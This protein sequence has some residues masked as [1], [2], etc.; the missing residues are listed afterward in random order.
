MLSS[1]LQTIIHALF[2][3]SGTYFTRTLV[4]YFSS[5][6]LLEPYFLLE[7][8][9]AIEEENAFFEGQQWTQETRFGFSLRFITILVDELFYT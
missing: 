8:F 7:L 5:I 9:T 1:T 4:S 6:I 2:R 3:C